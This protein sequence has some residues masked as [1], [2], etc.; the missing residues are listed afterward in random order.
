M[1]HGTHLALRRSHYDG[2]GSVQDIFAALDWRHE[3]FSILQ[4]SLSTR[5]GI[6]K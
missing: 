4:I 1:Q 6:V 2:R 5:K 3:G